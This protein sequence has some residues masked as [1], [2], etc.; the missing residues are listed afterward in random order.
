[1]TPLAYRQSRNLGACLHTRA[2]RQHG[3][4]NV[5][6][7]SLSG[8]GTDQ[9]D[10]HSPPAPGAKANAGWIKRKEDRIH[11]EGLPKSLEADGGKGRI[12]RGVDH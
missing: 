2:H 4:S 10:R 6:S 12:R 1:M 7:S 5:L 3:T 11:L 8:G 9:G